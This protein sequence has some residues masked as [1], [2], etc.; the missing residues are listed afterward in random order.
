MMKALI[1]IILFTVPVFCFSQ[2]ENIKSIG[3]EYKLIDDAF[4]IQESLIG[5]P[6]YTINT[7]H[8]FGV[9]YSIQFRKHFEIVNALNYKHYN[10]YIKPSF[11]PNIDMTP[12]YFDI[13]LF[14]FSSE[15]RFKFL[16]FFF[17]NLG[18]LADI[19]VSKENVIDNQTGLGAL[20]GIG[21]E[22]TFKHRLNL[23][24]NPSVQSHA[25][26]KFTSSDYPKRIFESGYRFGLRYCFPIAKSGTD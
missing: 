12:V 14:S 6:S 25:L 26:V 8:A 17:L 15:L 13:N 3:V 7:S 19:D 20:G 24:F 16:K 18:A 9:N 21:A 23:F 11:I 1:S 5:G 4:L 22:Y 2:N 10:A